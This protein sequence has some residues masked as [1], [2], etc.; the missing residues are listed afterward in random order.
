MRSSATREGITLAT[1][2]ATLDSLVERYRGDLNGLV[3]K[4]ES[5]GVGEKVKSWIGTG[6][7]ESISANE[8]KNALGS[9]LDEFAAKV[10]I[11]RDEAADELAQSL[12]DAVDKA[13]PTGSIPS[14][15]NRAV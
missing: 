7:N 10:G 3:R 15:Q 5:S 2:L 8:I 1:T 6:E 14:A 11:G 12:P 9:E 13:T 4:F